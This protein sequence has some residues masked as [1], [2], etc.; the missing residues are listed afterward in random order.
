MT[1]FLKD[2]MALVS[3]SAF[4]VTAMIWLDALSHTI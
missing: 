1:V 2:L 4:S 3:L